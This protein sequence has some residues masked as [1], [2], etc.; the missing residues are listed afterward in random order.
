MVSL[1]DFC[2][3]LTPEYGSVMVSGLC[4]Y[5][6]NLA[7]IQISDCDAAPMMLTVWLEKGRLPVLLKFK[8]LQL[9]VT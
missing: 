4:V 3:E 5:Y 8:L 1:H 2:Y 7:L 9:N 6:N